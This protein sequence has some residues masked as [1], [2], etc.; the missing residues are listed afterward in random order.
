MAQKETYYFP[1]MR[2][3]IDFLDNEKALDDFSSFR[4]R[5]K[6]SLM[7]Y[8]I[9]DGAVFVDREAASDWKASGGA[10]TRLESVID[11]WLR[12]GNYECQKFKDR[13][14]KKARWILSTDEQVTMM[15]LPE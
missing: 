10:D 5:L 15:L 3:E 14:A 1:G 12:A 8:L 13:Q 2:L 4:T 6:E 7:K 9:T 11:S